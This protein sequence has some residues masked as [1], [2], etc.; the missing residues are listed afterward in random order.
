MYIAYL[1]LALSM[2]FVG[3]NIA[4]GKEVVREVPV[5]LFSE[6]RFLIALLILGTILTA[7]KEWRCSLRPKNWLSLFW[8]A[9]FGVFLFSVCMLYG[10]KMTTAAAAGIISSTVPACIAL[11]SLFL[12]KEKL[13]R[14]NVAAVCLSVLGVAL[15]TF[16]KDGSEPGSA[17]A[18]GILLVFLAVVA[19]ALFTIYAKKLSGRLTPFQMATG[20]NAIGFI[21]FLP[22]ALW[23][24]SRFSL[25]G[26]HAQTWGLIVYYAVTASVLSFTLWYLGVK[27][28]PAAIAGLFTGMMPISAAIS[29]ALFLHEAF[30]WLHALGM[31]LVLCA[32]AAGTRHEKKLQTI[33][34]NG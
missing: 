3:I 7:R 29:S 9:F 24:L 32:I 22:L 13:T 26:I 18:L 14:N 6:I 31:L 2:A 19:E 30:T 11:L 1:Q 12:L 33:R 4:V 5:F 21:L 15:V 8:Q 25:A 16:S 34:G 27:K 10:V 20:V 28:V 23:D 17:H